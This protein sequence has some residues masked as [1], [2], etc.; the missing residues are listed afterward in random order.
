MGVLALAYGARH[1]VALST[2]PGFIRPSIL[3]R[4]INWYHQLYDCGV[5]SAVCTA[6]VD[7]CMAAVLFI[8][9]LVNA[10]GLSYCEA[11]S[12][13]LRCQSHNTK[14]RIIYL[15]IELLTLYFERKVRALECTSF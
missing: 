12:G 3:L 1:P 7:V 8:I 2:C 11:D 15:V 10:D 9:L 14:K 4:S 13:H 6:M 5:K